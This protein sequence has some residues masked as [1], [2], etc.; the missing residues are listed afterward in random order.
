MKPLQPNPLSQPSPE[1]RL[2]S[3]EVTEQYRL[4]SAFLSN[5]RC[6]LEGPRFTRLGIRKILYRRADV[7]A[8]LQAHTV[9]T[10]PAC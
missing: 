2:T 9:E 7:E 8:W 4:S 5:L 1:D 6:Q 10:K 3:R